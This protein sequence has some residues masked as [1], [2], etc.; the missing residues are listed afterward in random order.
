MLHNSRFG[1]ENKTRTHRNKEISMKVSRTFERVIRFAIIFGLLFVTAAPSF[2]CKKLFPQNSLVYGRTYSEWAA[3]WSQWALSI[4]VSNHPLF[5]NGDCS[6]GQTGPVWFLGGKFCDPID[7][8]CGFE[9]VER[10]CTVPF[11]KALFFP[12]VNMSSSSLEGY[13]DTIVELRQNSES[14][15]DYFFTDETCTISLTVDNKVVRE[16]DLKKKFHVHSRTFGFTLPEDNLLK[17][18]GVV[19]AVQ[20]DYYPAV[21]EGFYVMLKPLSPGMHTINFS[22]NAP[23][24][25][26]SLN[27]TYTINVEK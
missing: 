7:E 19:E 8:E 10:T 5:D 1:A 21:D 23:V 6:V 27:V 9:A 26:L 13:G 2:A 20:G 11:G 16:K 25:G 24:F 3:E 4:P 14:I 12:I 17:I 15:I 22:A 18:L